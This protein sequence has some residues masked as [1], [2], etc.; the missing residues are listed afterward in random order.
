MI[1][2]AQPPK[3][4]GDFL[5]TRVNFS[6]MGPGSA[7]DLKKLTPREKDVLNQLARGFRYKEIMDN[8]GISNGTLNSYICN[9][10]EKL[11]VH[12]RTEAVVKYLTC[13]P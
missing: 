5:L 13:Q 4:T 6:P 11:K 9:V 10:Y 3:S 1:M 12:S 7:S 8:L 2:R